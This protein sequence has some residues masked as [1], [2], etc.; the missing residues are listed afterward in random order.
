MPQKTLGKSRFQ[1]KWI[2][3]F[4]IIVVGI[5]TV[6]LFTAPIPKYAVGF[7]SINKAI[8]DSNKKYELAPM[9]TKDFRAPSWAKYHKSRK[10]SLLSNKFGNVLSLLGIKETPAWSPSYFSHILN[11]VVKKREAMNYKAPYAL[12]ISPSAKARFI[13]W[14]DLTG[15]YHSLVRGLKKV[16]DLGILNKNLKLV[17]PDDYIVF[18]GDAAGRSPFLME[19]ESLI[20]TLMDRNPDHV[21]YLMGNTEMKQEWHPYGMQEEFKLKAGYV[22]SVANLTKQ[23]DRFFETLPLALYISLYPHNSN[24]FLRMSHF[25]MGFPSTPAYQNI[26][27][28]GD[29]RYYSKKLMENRETGK[30][31]IIP[32]EMPS[33][34]LDLRPVKVKGIVRSFKKSR[35]YKPNKGL[36]R[37][38][39]DK[40]ASSWFLL[41]SPVV[42]VQ[43]LVQFYYDAFGIL[44][45]EPDIED[46]TITLYSRDMRTKE[47][48][49]SYTYKFISG[50]M[51]AENEKSVL[52]EKKMEMI[53]PIKRKSKKGKKPKKEKKKIAKNKTQTRIRR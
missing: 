6:I 10:S 52:R 19:M 22:D 26:V 39:P 17:R 7:V 9:E 16:V 4:L 12:R 48:F 18:M 14:G 1:F 42:I 44:Q 11:D 46:A 49:D 28:L 50:E 8:E 36:Q 32:L 51:V 23:M 25:A 34:D 43:K 40:D 20:M 15:A 35:M 53:D 27:K 13:I 5:L 47:P 30:D 33:G 45:L 2:F 3:L 37:L 21:I 41:S 31:K 29:D 24:D 38:K